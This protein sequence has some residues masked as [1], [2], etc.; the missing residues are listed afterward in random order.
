MVN[1]RGSMMD[2]RG[3]MKKRSCMNCMRNNSRCF[4][5]SFDHWSIH[6]RMSH[7]KCKRS[8]SHKRSRECKRSSCRSY[9]GS[10]MSSSWEVKASIEEELRISLSLTLMKTVDRLIASARERTSI[11][12]C[13]VW[14]VQVGVA[15]RGIVVQ[16]IGFRLSQAERGYGENYDLET[17]FISP[18]IIICGRFLPCTSSC[19]QDCCLKT[20]K[21]A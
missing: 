9:Q 6:N 18:C 20:S 12:R 11:A 17:I 15:I 8:R 1:K 21:R 13:R 7:W 3:S 10:N 16:G 5:N 19:V 14:S 2:E 4:Y